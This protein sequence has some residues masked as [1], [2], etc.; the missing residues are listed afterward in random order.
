MSEP[1]DEPWIDHRPEAA[2]TGQWDVREG[3]PDVNAQIKGL[4]HACVALYGND[5]R[6]PAIQISLAALAHN[7][8]FQRIYS[9]ALRAAL[10][11]ELASV[12]ATIEKGF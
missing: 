1:R 5:M 11:M 6:D 8:M 10:T 4:S 7:L 9:Y 3:P 2:T 12:E